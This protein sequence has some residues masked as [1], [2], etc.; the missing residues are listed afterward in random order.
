MPKP[1]LFYS[2]DKLKSLPRHKKK[3]LPFWEALIF[4]REDGIR[5]YYTKKYKKLVFTVLNSSFIENHILK[6]VGEIICLHT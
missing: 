1:F 4:C 3:M 6:Y 5:T 2:L